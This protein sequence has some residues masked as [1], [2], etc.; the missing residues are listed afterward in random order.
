[1]GTAGSLEERVARDELIPFRAIATGKVRRAGNPLL[2]LTPSNARDMARVPVGVLQAR[3]AVRE[4]GPDAVLA[5]G[6]V[7]RDPGRA[8]RRLVRRP[9]SGA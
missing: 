5:T 4:F 2:M 6:R 9:L 8:R 1:L 3:G 7:R